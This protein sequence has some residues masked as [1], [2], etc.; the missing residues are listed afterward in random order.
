M[1]EYTDKHQENYVLLSG[2]DSEEQQRI[3]RYSKTPRIGRTPRAYPRRHVHSRGYGNPHSHGHSRYEEETIIDDTKV[4]IHHLWNCGEWTS[5]S[6]KISIEYPTKMGGSGDMIYN[7]LH[8]ARVVNI[9]SFGNWFINKN[10][11]QL[12]VIEPKS[13]QNVLF[14]SKISCKR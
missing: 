13:F 9:N 6:E 12:T 10:Q 5:S 8:K 7:S 4:T 14:L 1:A 3:V 2:S 11:P